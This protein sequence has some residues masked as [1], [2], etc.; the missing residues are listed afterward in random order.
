MGGN[1]SIFSKKQDIIMKIAIITD[2]N[3]EDKKGAFIAT[4]NRIKYLSDYKDL[5]IDVFII[6]EYEN[7][8]IR[9]LR[10]TKKV[11]QKAFF[12]YD[13]ITYN[14]LW[15][16]F[17]LFNYFIRVKLNIQSPFVVFALRKWINLFRNY[18]LL[19]THSYI[20]GILAFLVNDKYNIPYS[21][22]WHGSEIHT[23]PQ[24]NFTIR[25]WTKRL[26][27]NAQN[28]F[29][30]SQDLLNKSNEISYGLNKSVLYNGVDIKLF[31]KKEA[32]LV[33]CIRE[34]YDIISNV[35]IAFIGNLV[36]IKNAE[37]LPNIFFEISKK[38]SDI[39]FHVIGDG[40]LRFQ[41]ENECKKLSLPVV[42]Y[43]NQPPEQIPLLINCMNLIIL[44]SKNE[45]L[46]LIA[47]EALAC[48]V[49]II[50]SRVGGIPEAI[51]MENTIS[52]ED[53]FIVK[54][55]NLAIE[56]INNTQDISIPTQ[57]SWE[58]TAEL[59]YNIY[60]RMIKSFYILNS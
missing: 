23:D 44:P 58:K 20:P 53:N 36:S 33:K 22:T 26:I 5:E 4:H 16:K 37:L 47:L 38:S 14:N 55:S 3:S 54:L 15:N 39:F 10:K 32:S 60:K 9:K 30:V 8:V 24:K 40:K 50:G 13:G 27:Q 35:N 25:K 19:S 34:Q 52:L 42:F 2:G 59:E 41:I 6:Q 43:G 46:P 12:I 1:P 57:F 51:G 7:W 11:E 17:S 18:E 31:N 29:F 49:P 48:G 28:N 56:I 21:I 45:G